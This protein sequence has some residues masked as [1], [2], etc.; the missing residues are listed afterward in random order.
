[1]EEKVEKEKKDI[2][3]EEKEV[4]NEEILEKVAKAPFVGLTEEETKEQEN[5]KEISNILKALTADQMS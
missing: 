3:S 5:L 2:K 4:K 1:M